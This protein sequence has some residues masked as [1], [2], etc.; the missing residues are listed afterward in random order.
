MTIGFP[1]PKRKVDEKLLEHVRAQPCASCGALPPSDPSHLMSRGA[2]GPDSE[3]NVAPQCRVCHSL[4]HQLG[5]RSFVRRF[6]RFQVWLI[7]HGWQVDANG[8]PSYDVR[9]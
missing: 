9:K 2:G 8:A 6:P 1:K 5:P 3:Y 4:W 7:D